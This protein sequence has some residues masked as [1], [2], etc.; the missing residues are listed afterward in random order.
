MSGDSKPALRRLGLM[1]QG[2]AAQE[3]SDAEA[4]RL[5]LETLCLADDL[6]FDSSWV[7]EHHNVRPDA[8]F[9]GRIP[10]SE[11]FLAYAAAQ[12]K[13]IRVGTGV[14]ILS[15]TSPQR[16][17]EE[18][19][20]LSLLSGAR[21]E[22]GIGLGANQIVM[23]SREE[24]ARDFRERFRALFGIL[25]NEPEYAPQQ[26]SP[27]PTVDLTQRIWAAA[28]DEPTLEFL[29]GLGANLVVGQA[30]PGPSQAQYTKHYRAAGGK[31]HIRGVRLVFVAPT[32]EAAMEESREAADLYYKLMS[33]GGYV[34][35]AIE[36]GLIPAIAPTR[37][38]MLDRVSFIVGTPDIVARQLNDY[39]ALTGVDQVD[40]MVQIPRLAPRAIHR[41]MRLL[42]EEVRP[43]LLFR[44][45]AACD[46]AA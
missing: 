36:K 11:I 15:T 18:M 1:D 42:Q 24:K 39:I 27:K 23:M 2:W 45:E 14:K 5:T 22:F 19:S 33:N 17:A 40:A 25:R 46:A 10:A 13:R 12:T 21:A 41:S 38:D 8:P 3:T 7:G 29:A 34:K 16:T 37:E 4:M 44:P 9:Y 43:Q 35:E 32:M 6:G 20:L 28:R 26:L 30:E 31:G